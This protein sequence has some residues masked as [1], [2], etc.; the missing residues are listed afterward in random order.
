[1]NSDQFRRYGHDMIDQIARYMEEVESYPV[2][3]QSAPGEVRQQLNDQAPE[4]GEDFETIIDD[5]ERIIMP[6]ITHWQSPNFLWIFS[7]ES[8]RAI[9]T[10]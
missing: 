7:S 3:A 5:F 1:M 10:R 9:N 4:I 6:G 2:Q 8:F